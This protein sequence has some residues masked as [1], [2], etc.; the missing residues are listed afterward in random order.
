M[1]NINILF[2]QIM[3]EIRSQQADQLAAQRALNDLFTAIANGDDPSELGWLDQ[4]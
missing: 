2:N 3:A 1:S 4:N